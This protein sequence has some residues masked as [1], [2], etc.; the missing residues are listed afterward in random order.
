[1]S[2]L[3]WLRKL[4]IRSAVFVLLSFTLAG[5][6]LAADPDPSP[7]PSP[8][9]GPVEPVGPQ[10]PVGPQGVVGPIGLVG[11]QPDPS[12]QAAPSPD[13]TS[14]PAASATGTSGGASNTQTGSNSNNQNSTTANNTSTGTENNSATFNNNVAAD[15]TTGNNDL[16]QNT[17]LGDVTTGAVNG[18]FNLINVGNSILA[19]GSSVGMQSLNAGGSGHINLAPS[20]TRTSLSGQSN[21]Q[22]G[23]NSDNG[24]AFVTNNLLKVVSNNQATANNNVDVNAN[25]GDNTLAQNTKAGNLKTG[26][27]NL[28]VNVINLMNLMMP[29]LE[30]S[31]DVWSLLTSNIDSIIS[32]PSDNSQTGSNSNNANSVTSSNTKNIQITKNAQANNDV[33]VNATTGSNTVAGNTESGDVTT[34]QTKV[35]GSEVTIANDDDPTFYIVNV[36]GDWNGQIQGIPE[37]SY[38][39]N[40]LDNSQTGSNSNN[41]NSVNNTNEEDLTVNQQ[42]TVNNHL[43]VHANT[44]G[45]SLVGNTTVGGLKTGSVNVLANLINILNS[46]SGIQGKFRLGIINIFSAPAGSSSS[47]NDPAVP[48]NQGGVVSTAEQLMPSIS[49]GQVPELKITT[50][51]GK[52]VNLAITPI[53]VNPAVAAAAA[54]PSVTLTSSTGKQLTLATVPT[55]GEVAGASTDG[56]SSSPLSVIILSLLGLGA[57]LWLGTEILNVIAKRR[58]I[59]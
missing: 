50:A 45:N 5:P 33:N 34:G 53:Q 40:H 52:K 6:V 21:S 38:V 17:E 13:P 58:T 4:Q 8:V 32:V 24:N 9:V 39:I 42:A 27:I 57:V 26:D 49:Q 12:P 14:S 30:L 23:S 36:M 48:Q 15:A 44:G 16:N 19:P 46:W 56:D 11:P 31:V 7:S 1:M 37:G 41:Q 20:A 55:K 3:S 10:L 29:N 25:T 59:A 28:A 22:T 54:T 43:N 51:S 2:N 35:G 47:Q 18:S